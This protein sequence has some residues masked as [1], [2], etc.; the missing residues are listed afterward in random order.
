M[1]SK[2][3]LAI[4][5]LLCI[6]SSYAYDYQDFGWWEVTINNHTNKNVTVGP[7]ENSTCFE[8]ED[9]IYINGNK[10]N[11]MAYNVGTVRSVYNSNN[12][13][14]SEP[15]TSVAAFQENWS[16][17]NKC[18]KTIASH[19]AVLRLK[20]NNSPADVIVTTNTFSGFAKYSVEWNKAYIEQRSDIEPYLASTTTSGDFASTISLNAGNNSSVHKVTI[21]ILPSPGNM[22]LRPKR[23]TF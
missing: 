16:F 10:V 12:K 11:N 9:T 19:M 21:N 23:N 20:I 5:S 17:F 22:E 2:L 6:G 1:K 15:G 14:I 4:L 8:R 3:C 18:G 7:Y 13:L